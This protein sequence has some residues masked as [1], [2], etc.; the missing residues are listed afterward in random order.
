M[1]IY[2]GNQEIVSVGE[3]KLGGLDVQQVYVGDVLIWP[4]VAQ[5]C[6]YRLLE[7]GF[8]RLTEGGDYRV[9][10]D[11][12]IGASPVDSVL[13]RLPNLSGTEITAV[14]NFINCL[15]A[16]DVWD[17]VLNVWGF[18]LNQFDYLTPW[19][20][21]TTPGQTG[22]LV[23]SSTPPDYV[24]PE[25]R[26]RFTANPSYYRTANTIDTFLASMCHGVFFYL[27]GWTD[28][29]G[30]FPSA[31]FGAQDAGGNGYYASWR[32]SPQRDYDVQLGTDGP[33]PR[34]P[35]T[36]V[37]P[38]EDGRWGDADQSFDEGVVGAW[39]D[40]NAATDNI[41]TRYDD[42]Q[43]GAARSETAL[44]ALQLQIW[45]INPNGDPSADAIQP[46]YSRLLVILDDDVIS[47]SHVTALNDCILQ[48]MR[49]LGVPNVPPPWEP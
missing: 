35:D 47:S 5:V 39:H 34:P 48:F 13:A 15:I 41:L 22:A 1:P 19:I 37:Q 31:I 12:C 27:D 11:G 14:T 10:E 28:A 45:G 25:S 33:I 2:V 24:I 16:G 3:I 32:G 46:A 40:G 17:K 23:P 8:R 29:D 44:P 6:S 49:D 18:G 38:I 20:D 43:R 36:V 7:D 9:L 21:E 30:N 4:T 42:E 26:V